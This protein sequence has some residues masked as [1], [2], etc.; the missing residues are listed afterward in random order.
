MALT[1]IDLLS[2]TLS[3][4]G[5]NLKH[6]GVV[7]KTVAGGTTVPLSMDNQSDLFRARRSQC[8]RSMSKEVVVQSAG[9]RT[10]VCTRV[11]LRGTGK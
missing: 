1:L 4:D 6:G 11:V 3:G 9:V 7:T 8:D 5:R 10:R 2:S